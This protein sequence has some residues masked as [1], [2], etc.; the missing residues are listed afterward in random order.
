[1]QVGAHFL[2]DAVGN[3]VVDPLKGQAVQ[4]VIQGTGMEQYASQAGQSTD[5]AIYFVR[6]MQDL[7]RMFFV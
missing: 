2:K 4:G 7:Q 5:S 6:K 1:V 3:W